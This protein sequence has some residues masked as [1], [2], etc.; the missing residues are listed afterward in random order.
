MMK[1]IIDKLEKFQLMLGI[2]C[3]S[4]YLVCTLLQIFCRYFDISIPWTEEISNYF[5]IWAV[6]MGASIMLR[7]ENGHFSLTVLKDKLQ[8]KGR[9]TKIL[10]II[11]ASFLLLFSVLVFVYGIELTLQFKNWRLSSL[12]AIHQWVVWLCMP[13]AGFT[14]SVYSLEKLVKAMCKK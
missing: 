1:N 3:L 8:S 11:I 4:G 5:F 7:V 6:F 10:E 9:S 13:V 14:T 12:P 2:I